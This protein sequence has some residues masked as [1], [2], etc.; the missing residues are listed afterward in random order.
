MEVDQLPSH[1]LHPKGIL[2]QLFSLKGHYDYKIALWIQNTFQKYSDELCF[3]MIQNKK[4]VE[5]ASYVVVKKK[6]RKF[7]KPIDKKKKLSK[8]N[9][10]NKQ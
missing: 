7:K 4:Y 2:Y 6:K 9:K 3:R 1:V 10:K 5:D 8:E